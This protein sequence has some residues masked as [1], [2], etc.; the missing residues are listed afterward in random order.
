MSAKLTKQQEIY[1]NKVFAM[2]DKITVDAGYEPT[3]ENIPRAVSELVAQGKTKDIY[4][5][6]DYLIKNGTTKLTDFHMPDHV[7]HPTPYQE[8]SYIQ[9]DVKTGGEG[10]SMDAVGFSLEYK[11]SIYKYFNLYHE[12]KTTAFLISVAY[13]ID[14]STNIDL[15]LQ[16]LKL[17]Q[18]YRII[19]TLTG[20]GIWYGPYGKEKEFPTIDVDTYFDAS[21]V[22][23]DVIIEKYNKHLK[24]NKDYAAPEYST[25]GIDW[26]QYGK[27]FP[28]EDLYEQEIPLNNPSKK[29]ILEILESYN[30]S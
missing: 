23:K 19:A 10:D 17:N 3:M 9:L 6:L 29:V 1:N 27:K 5:L 13:F 8:T 18:F 2:I 4:K 24:S 26:Y 30:K 21:R 11:E 15:C 14:L 25:T 12:D 20:G 22:W 16:L 28:E 7:E